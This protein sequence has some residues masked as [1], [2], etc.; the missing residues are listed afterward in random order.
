MFKQKSV[1]FA[2]FLVGES[3]KLDFQKLPSTVTR[4]CLTFKS[5]QLTFPVPGATV[6]FLKLLN[7]KNTV[8][9]YLIDPLQGPLVDQLHPEYTHLI[10]TPINAL[11]FR[12]LPYSVDPIFAQRLTQATSC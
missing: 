1:Y 12:F 5:R 9:S 10:P 7:T 11:S 6:Q 4:L 2:L 3:E 8:S